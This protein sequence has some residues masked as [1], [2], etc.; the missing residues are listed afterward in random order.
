[1]S[2][3]SDFFGQALARRERKAATD[4]LWNQGKCSKRIWSL[5]KEF[6]K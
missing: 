5:F 1:M 3:L 6:K 2:K 4:E